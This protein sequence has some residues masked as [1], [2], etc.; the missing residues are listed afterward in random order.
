MKIVIDDKIPFIRD[1]FEPYADVI[2][3]KGSLIDKD[4]VSDADALIVRTRTKCNKTL[5]SGSK[6]KIVATATIG[7][8]HID[9][10]WCEDNGIKWVNAP[11]CNSGSVMQYITAS[12]FFLAS[13]H[14][15]DLRSLTLGVVGVG[16]VGTKVVA[17]AKAIGMKVLQNDPP[18]KRKEGL[19][20]FISLDKLLAQSDIVTFHVPYTKEGHDK[21]HYL[22]NSEN[23]FT[24]KEGSILINS[25]RGEVVD[26]T[27]LLGALKKEYLSGAVLDVWEAEPNADKRLI[28][29]VDISTPHIAGYSVDGKA[30]G[31]I[32]AVHEVAAV[33]GLPLTEW[34][35]LSLPQ[36]ANPVIDL[37]P[38]IKSCT[39][40]E[41]TNLAVKTTYPI[42]KDNSE[43]K[44]NPEMF[45]SLRDNYWKRREFGSYTVVVDDDESRQI[46]TKL[47]FKV[48]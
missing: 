26:N 30:N 35:P 16:N 12:L 48:K 44:K 17:A 8:D 22:I 15:L 37:T 7:F 20:S 28:E 47:G 39:A 31:T 1:T 13:K 46:L 10:A 38:F 45:E 32:K 21:T 6:V 24:M 40:V 36:P 3:C 41:L 4:L 18:R 27:A 5:L 9:T 42:A 43:F 33:L 11:G 25:S 2:Y 29:R 34:V 23:L 19:N 14:S